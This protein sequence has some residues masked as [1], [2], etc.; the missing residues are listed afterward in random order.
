[1]QRTYTHKLV[2]TAFHGGG[3]IS[4]HTSEELAERAAKRWRGDTDCTCGCCV[5]VPIL[6]TLRGAHEDGV[7]P[8]QAAT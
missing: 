1:M 3:V 4:H 2:K 6:T 5:A 7:S 8:Y